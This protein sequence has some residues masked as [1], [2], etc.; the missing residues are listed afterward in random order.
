MPELKELMSRF[1]S[2]LEA[3]EEKFS[4]EVEA[5]GEAWLQDNINVLYTNVLKGAAKLLLANDDDIQIAHD[6]AIDLMLASMMLAEQYRI[7]L[8]E[9]P[10]DIPF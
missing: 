5:N 7:M 8:G 1:S 2:S 3:T 9:D 6:I 10:G 4:A